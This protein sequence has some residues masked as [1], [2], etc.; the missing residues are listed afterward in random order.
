MRRRFVR[1]SLLVKILLSTIKRI[2]DDP[3]RLLT[4]IGIKIAA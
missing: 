4:A 3:D 2:S 1:L